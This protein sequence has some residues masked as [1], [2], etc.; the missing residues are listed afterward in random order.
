MQTLLTFRRCEL[1]P[2]HFLPR[3]HDVFNGEYVL[4]QH[5]ILLDQCSP[6]DLVPLLDHLQ[7]SLQLGRIHGSL[8]PIG[9][10]HV[11]GGRFRQ[12]L[13]QEPQPLLAKGHGERLLPIR[14]R[15]HV[16]RTRCCVQLLDLAG[17][18]GHRRI[19]E[20]PPQRHFPVKL[21]ADARDHRQGEQRVPAKLEEIVLYADSFQ[22]Q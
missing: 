12:R 9:S 19:L 2:V 8:Q 22:T 13:L 11:I 17:Q 16:Y 20:Q 15:Y 5:L 21:V 7:A 10:R 1:P 14:V 18:A 6:Q 4:Q 3:Q